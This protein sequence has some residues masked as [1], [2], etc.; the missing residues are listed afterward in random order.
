MTYCATIVLLV[1]WGFYMK[2]S[3][4]LVGVDFSAFLEYNQCSDFTIH[5]IGCY[6]CNPGYS[7]GPNIRP[8][9]IIHYVIS[10]RGILILNGIK[11]E[12]KSQQ[13]FLIPAGA[14]A[15]YEAD[16]DNPWNYCWMHISGRLLNDFLYQA[17]LDV[18]HPIFVPKVLNDD[19]EIILNE[20]FIN[21][22]SPY[23]VIGKTYEFF[24]VLIQN[25]TRKNM[26][27]IDAQMTYVQKTIKYIQTKYSLAIKVEDIAN[28]LG[29]N[30]SYL[31]R[32]FKEAT[33]S[34]IQDYLLKYRM[35]TATDLLENHNKTVSYTAFAVGYK[36]A[37]T[38][39]KAYKRY[40]GKNPSS[41]IKKSNN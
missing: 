30:R 3:N 15:Y 19:L 10:G 25:S 26:L 31:S 9:P 1:K 21:Y 16:N 23:L 5:E 2:T 8:H 39:S 7:Y 11:H 27:K 37:F 18:N 4:N 41:V 36:D 14:Y 22:Q 29:V 34:S 40:T 24:H 28:I 13:A 6:Q 35:T 33:G 20:I 17:G 38:F 12:V 32:L